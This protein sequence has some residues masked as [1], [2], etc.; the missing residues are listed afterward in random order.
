MSFAKLLDEAVKQKRR[1]GRGGLVQNEP[2]RSTR[3][4]E[5]ERIN[6]AMKAAYHAGDKEAARKIMEEGR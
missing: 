4:Q 6:N 2:Y 5:A 1:S 3:E